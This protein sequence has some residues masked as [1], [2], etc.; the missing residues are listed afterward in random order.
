MRPIYELIAEGGGELSPEFKA[1]LGW[2]VRVLPA[3]TPRLILSYEGEEVPEPFR[4]Y[5]DATGEGKV[6]SITFFPRIDSGLPILLKGTSD[7]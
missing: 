7:G 6:A 2:R 3:I 1:R 5:S 4:L